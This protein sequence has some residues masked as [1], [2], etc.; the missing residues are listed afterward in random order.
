V[1]PSEIAAKI[2]QRRRQILVH[3]II[4]YRFGDNII[5]DH[6]WAEWARELVALQ[7]Q[8]PEIAA[9]CPLA[10]AF[11]D[12]D[13]STGYDLPLGDAHYHAVARWLLDEHKRRIT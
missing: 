10:E 11:K 8:Y 6:K 13:A 7:A 1:D 3:S 4:Y 5:P 2:S 9:T 12:F